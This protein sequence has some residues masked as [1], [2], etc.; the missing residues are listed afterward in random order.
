M[1]AWLIAIAFFFGLLIQQFGLPPLVGFL[2]AGFVLN[3]MGW[4]GGEALHVLSEMGVTLM[5]FAIG[6]KLRLKNLLRP[7]VWLGTTVHT[8]GSTLLIAAV[9]LFAGWLG[10]PLL[11]SLPISSA[12]LLGFALSFSSTVFAVKMLEG[13]GEM[14]AL[15][16]RVAIGILVMQDLLAVMFLTAST[17]KVPSWW[18][19]GFLAVLIALRPVIGWVLNRCGHGELIALCGLFLALVLGAKGFESVGLKA[20]LGA[21]FIG[22]LAGQ[23]DKAKEMSKSL[24][25]LTDLLL[26]GFFLSIGLEGLPDWQGV[27]AALLIVSL[28][29]F[30]MALFFLL[31]TRCHLRAR[32]SWMTGLTLG[33]YSEFGLIVMSLAVGKLWLPAEWLVVVA[34]AL[35]LSILLAAPINRRAESIY[36]WLSEWLHRF[37]SEGQHPDD[38]PVKLNGEFI[39]IFGMGR[40]GLSAYKVMAR[41]FAGKVIGF[42][43]D[44]TQVEDHQQGG[45][46]VVLADATDSDFWHRVQLKDTIELV[47]LAMPKHSANLH[48]AETLKR[49]GFQGVVAAT[50][51]FDDEVRELKRLGLDTVFNLYHEAGA[52]F[53]QHVSNVFRQQRPDLIGT[54]RRSEPDDM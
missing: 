16:G 44:P 19:L 5:L 35:S 30:K 15:H 17:G 47:V 45:L 52:G 21:L 46:N 3:G 40:V 10:L 6:L 11:S 4:S 32:T 48:A 31:L 13:S 25:G 37:E 41:R 53:A 2:V 20:D 42:D 43:R 33:S 50:A 18:A 1:D 28:L 9:L 51:K 49:N 27:L 39:A 7:E 34:I 8:V 22:V 14:G 54:A 38:I 24:I 26:V 29:P 23:H 12:L 36:D